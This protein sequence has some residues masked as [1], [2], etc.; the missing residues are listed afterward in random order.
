MFRP[1]AADFREMTEFSGG[2]LRCELAAPIDKAFGREDASFGAAT[3]FCPG[4]IHPF[5]LVPICYL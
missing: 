4:T 3:T 5:Y 1:K 2:L